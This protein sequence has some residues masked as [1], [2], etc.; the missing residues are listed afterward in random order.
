MN[1]DAPD[2]IKKSQSSFFDRIFDPF[3]RLHRFHYLY[4]KFTRKNETDKTKEKEQLIQARTGFVKLEKL[5]KTGNVPM[6]K[7]LDS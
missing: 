5:N 6:I 2:D 4:Y 3:G 1:T 7:V